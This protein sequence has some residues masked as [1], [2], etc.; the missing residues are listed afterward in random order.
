LGIAERPLLEWFAHHVRPGQTWLDI[1][2]H[3]GYTAL[4]LARSVGPTGRVFAFEALPRTA[5]TLAHTKLA[6]GL[7]QLVVVPL[8]LGCPER[9][10]RIETCPTDTGMVT[11]GDPT[12]GLTESMYV[13]S[14]DRLWP[15]LCGA[16]STIDGVKIDVQGWE[17]E[18][19]RG[20]RQL[21][22]RHQPLL[23]VETHAGV[24]RDELLNLLAS[25]NYDAPPRSIENGNVGQPVGQ[26]LDNTTYDFRP[27]R[28]ASR[29]SSAP[30]DRRAA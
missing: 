14:L 19:L 28:P 29:S 21:L 16:D 4:A 26:L 11:Y 22:A 8:G 10:E 23:A 27:L 30:Q 5:G 18:T 6:N 15:S 24:D 7:P 3:H 20:M 9:L 13:E 12:P 2:A 25:V 1:G 17:I